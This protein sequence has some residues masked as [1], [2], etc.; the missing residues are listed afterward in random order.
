MKK[1]LKPINLDKC[2]KSDLPVELQ[3]LFAQIIDSKIL[4]SVK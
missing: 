2:V 1:L 4:D 3:E